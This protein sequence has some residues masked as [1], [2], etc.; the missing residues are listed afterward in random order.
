MR[1]FIRPQQSFQRA[2]DILREAL[3]T[4]F[5][6]GSPHEQDSAIHVHPADLRS[7]LDALR[8]EGISGEPDWE[9]LHRERSST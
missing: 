8:S 3:P 6:S 9:G 2:V 5:K 7:V 4:K 1:V